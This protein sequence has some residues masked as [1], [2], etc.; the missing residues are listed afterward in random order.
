MRP[1]QRPPA[2]LAVQLHAGGQDVL[3]VDG[4]LP[5]PELT[6]IEVAGPAVQARFGPL[7]AQE[8]VAGCLHQPLARYHPLALVGELAGADESAEHRRLGFLNLQE[9]RIGVIAAEHQDDPAARSDAADTDDFARD[10]TELIPLEQVPAVGFQRALV[11]ADQAG[12]PLLDGRPVRLHRRQLLDRN[13]QRRVGDDPGP[14]VHD[15]GQLADFLYAVPGPRLGQ[16]LAHQLALARQK[17][18]FELLPAFG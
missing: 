2:E 7:P 5:V 6:D 12:E 1:G 9:Q 14:A 15:L 13:Q 8:D 16:A 4:E 10:V 3:D 17:L 18:G 11:L